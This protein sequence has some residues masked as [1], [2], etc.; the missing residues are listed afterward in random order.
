M[1]I[2]GDEQGLP[3]SFDEIYAYLEAHL[4]KPNRVQIVVEEFVGMHQ[5]T[6]SRTPSPIFRQVDQEPPPDSDDDSNQGFK[7]K[8]K[9]IGKN[10]RLFKP[11]KQEPTSTVQADISAPVAMKRSNSSPPELPSASEETTNSHKKIKLGE[12]ETPE[13]E[14]MRPILFRGL[15]GADKTKRKRPA[16]TEALTEDMLHG[17]FNFS[18]HRGGGSK[19]KT[20]QRTQNLPSALHDI[21]EDSMREPVIR[22]QPSVVTGNFVL[23]PSRLGAKRDVEK[24]ATV[25]SGS[26]VMTPPR[27]RPKAI[28]EE[29]EVPPQVPQPSKHDTPQPLVN[30]LNSTILIADSPMAAAADPAPRLK[31]PHNLNSTITIADSPVAAAAD[32]SPR[33]RAPSIEVMREE[34]IVDGRTAAAGVGGEV[35]EIPDDPADAAEISALA[36]NLTAMFPDTPSVYIRQRCVDLVGKPA[37]I[38][39]FTEELLTDPNPPEDWE[40]IYK[41]PFVI[42]DDPL[43]LAEAAVN[44]IT[45]APDSGH[46]A[47]VTASVSIQDDPPP[48]L[49]GSSAK[50]EQQAQPSTSA[51]SA[52]TEVKQDLDPVVEWELERHGQMLS[53]FP[54]ICPDYL[55]EMVR[56]AIPNNDQAADNAPVN[57]KD[58]DGVFGAKVESLFA[59]RTEERRALPTRVQ[60]ETKK[61]AKEELEKWSGNMSVNDMLVLY[62]DDPEGHFCNPERK[63]ESELYKVHAVEGLKNE[64]R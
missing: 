33:L 53:M 55:M 18:Q 34:V 31:A 24:P 21:V 42:V 49:A 45:N 10:S 12:E 26:F 39:R 43:A 47:S 56:S 19:A 22:K 62:S 8:G 29:E 28:E 2:L 63:P 17:P 9:G 60:W 50:Q 51:S 15:E 11:V 36:D 6:I 38:E 59:M 41:K 1:R 13:Q 30:N 40:R 61:K 20:A 25:T 7:D 44:A 52:S 16:K 23:S 27:F 5:A 3:R 64:F 14:Q 54:D 48:A 35:V 4:E 32:P 57:L 58:L 37:A 46:Q